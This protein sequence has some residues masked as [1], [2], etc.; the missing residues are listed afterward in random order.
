MIETKLNLK[1]SFFL[2]ILFCCAE[3]RSEIIGPPIVDNNY[4]LDLRQ[5]PIIGSARQVALGGA[6][7]GVAEGITSL[8]SNPAGVAF[9]L[10]RSKTE[11]DWDWTVGL[12]NLKSN[13]FDNNGVS[14]PDYKTHR[15][16]SLG[17]MGQYGPW[18]IGVLNN[19]EILSLDGLSSDDEYVLSVTSLALGRQFLDRELT[20]GAGMRATMTKLQNQPFDATLGKIS[21]TGWD[22]G[23]VWNP[24]RG[25]FRFGVA[26][27]S[28]ISSDQSLDN[29]SGVPV[30]VNGLIVPQQVILP[31]SLGVGMSYAVPSA[32]FWKDHKWL[33][34]SDLLF[35]AASENAVGVESVLAQKIQYVGTHDTTSVRLGSE[36]ETMPG[37]LRLRLGSYYEPSNYEGVQSRTHL[38]GGFEVRMFHTSYW[39][40]YD[41]GLTY[42]VDSARDYLNMFVALGFWYF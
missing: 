14:P 28:S 11:F 15:I 16:R 1:S 10:E 26:Y 2:V 39:G 32:P 24:E 21:G 13:D 31:A 4:N 12:N 36:L 30:T 8:N 38:T 18:G 9:R 29:A 33:V 40:E 27:T 17:L 42:T 34:A 20:V 19:S 5:G 25:P 22:V 23:A 3:A 37:R 35:T 7:I 6:Y 41:W